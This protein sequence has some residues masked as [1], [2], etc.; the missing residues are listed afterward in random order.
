MKKKKNVMEI[1][2][3]IVEKYGFIYDEIY[4]SNFTWVFTREQNSIKQR[5]HV[6]E[7]RFDKVLM[8]RFETTAW[9]WGNS[10]INAISCIPENKYSGNQGGMWRYEDEEGFKKNLGEFAEIIEK[11]GID[12]LNE[13][14]I[15]EEV[16]PTN[17]MGKCLL[18][19]HEELSASFINKYQLEMEQRT[20]EDVLKWFDIIE[21]SMNQSKDQSYESVKEELIETTA[22]LGEQLRKEVG[23]EWNYQLGEYRSLCI[24]ELNC[25]TIPSYPILRSV[26]KAW[27][28]QSIERFREVY[29]FM[30]D[31][32]L[33]LEIEEMEKLRIRWAK[34]SSI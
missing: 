18:V 27:K 2:G 32:K 14:S 13:I 26:I 19:S 17:E 28:D 4:K 10:S 16:I 20:T 21:K 3:E 15:E 1:V 33:P 24:R 8:L 5:I 30:L 34:I 29:L 23:G 7:S 11:Y 6:V 12:K 25:Y 22:F 31:A 9:V